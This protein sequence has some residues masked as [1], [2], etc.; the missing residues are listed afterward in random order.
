[1]ARNLGSRGISSE[2]IAQIGFSLGIIIN[3]EDGVSRTL[4]IRQKS[5]SAEFDLS[6][7]L[8][9]K[10]EFTEARGPTRYRVRDIANKI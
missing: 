2:T 9:V 7:F 10:L 6:R 5:L 3:N 8:L 4:F 1:M